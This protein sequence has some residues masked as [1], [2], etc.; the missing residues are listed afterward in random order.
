MYIQ[1]V[2]ISNILTGYSSSNKYS[3]FGIVN[4]KMILPFELSKFEK[5]L[6]FH[7]IK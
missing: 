6:I 2:N 3:I 4:L 7:P 5:R 1:S